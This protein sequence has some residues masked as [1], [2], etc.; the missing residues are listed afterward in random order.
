MPGSA[1]SKDETSKGGDYVGGYPLQV[2]A[3]VTGRRRA[4][5]GLRVGVSRGALA[6][7]PPPVSWERLP[8]CSYHR[9]PWAR[10]VFLQTRLRESCLP[11]AASGAASAAS[12]RSRPRPTRPRPQPPPVPVPSPASLITFPGG[13]GEPRPEPHS[14][15]PGD[16]RSVPPRAAGKR[17]FLTPEAP[18]WFS[19]HHSQERGVHPSTVQRKTPALAVVGVWPR[20][21]VC[22]PPV[23]SSLLLRNVLVRENDPPK[24]R[25]EGRGGKSGARRPA[26]PGSSYPAAR[27]PQSAAA[28]RTPEPRRERRRPRSDQDAAGRSRACHGYI[29]FHEDE[30]LTSAPSGGRCLAQICNIPT[31][32]EG[33]FQLIN[34]NKWVI[35]MLRKRAW[36]GD[37]RH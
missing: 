11:P 4:L 1:F 16:F 23:A 33:N 29:D 34:M 25:Q 28:P 5:P 32:T 9:R 18:A 3:A 21:R 22:G 36:L 12:P 14:G 19:L 20:S 27:A 24:E 26:C 31:K 17:L 13:G 30:P 35:K 10:P 15:H 2:R 37:H 6:A 8:G 7:S